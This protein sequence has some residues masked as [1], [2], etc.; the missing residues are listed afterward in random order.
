MDETCHSQF[1]V[2]AGFSQFQ[3]ST[4]ILLTWFCSQAW[5]PKNHASVKVPGPQHPAFD[6]GNQLLP[7]RHVGSFGTAVITP[8]LAA[9][10][11]LGQ[12]YADHRCMGLGLKSE[13]QQGHFSM[14]WLVVSLFVETEALGIKAT[15]KVSFASHPR[16]IPVWAEAKIRRPLPTAWSVSEKRG[17]RQRLEAWRLQFGAGF[18]SVGKRC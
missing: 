5:G 16:G 1:A 6:A 3:P 14:A 9:I 13:R 12:K 4:R 7:S 10:H 11:V 2:P 18:L 17:R 15:D 8:T